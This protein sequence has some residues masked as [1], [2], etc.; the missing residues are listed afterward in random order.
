MRHVRGCFASCY[1]ASAQ[2]FSGPGALSFA[3]SLMIAFIVFLLGGFD[4]SWS[5]CSSY[6]GRSSA[7]MFDQNSLKFSVSS[8]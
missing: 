1:S 8:G 6:G 7:Y 3:S 5:L 2:M 4:A